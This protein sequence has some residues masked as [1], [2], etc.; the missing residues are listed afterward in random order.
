M[1]VLRAAALR[2]R[3]APMCCARLAACRWSSSTAGSGPPRE[4][5]GAPAGASPGDQTSDALSTSAE[6]GRAPGGLALQQEEELPPVAF[7]PGVVGAAQKGVS[8]VVIAFG[9]VAFGACAWGISQALFPGPTSTQSIYDEAFEKVRTNGDVA[10]ALGTPLRAFGADRGSDRGRRNAL[11]R[12][13][14]NEGGEDVTVLRFHVAGPQGSGT[15]HVQTPAE[16][17]RGDFKYI[18]FEH[19]RKMIT[20][21]DRRDDEA[22]AKAAPPTPPT[23]PPPAPTPAPTPAAA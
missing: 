3:V 1:L 23:P 17:K 5:A 6:D 9:A 21:L 16:R 14:L 15:V 11:D 13:E 19:R 22:D 20:V 7:E 8:A 12:W 10:Y 18:M 4:G 2:G